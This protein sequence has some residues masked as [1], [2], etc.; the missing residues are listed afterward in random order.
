MPH[1]YFS[2]S[3]QIAARFERRRR[4][5]VVVAVLYALGGLVYL[6]W[7]LTIFNDAS[8]WVSTLYYLAECLGYLLGLTVI[9]GAWRYQHR[10]PQSVSHGYDVDVLIP[11]YKEP[12]GV[13]RKT[14]HAAR[15]IRYPHQ[16]WVLDDAGRLEI[17]A[18]ARELGVHYRARGENWD[19][20]A[21]NLN[22]G[23]RESQ[24]EFVA[25]FDAD[26]IAQPDALDLLLG[27]M[28][29]PCVAMVQT[30]QD[31]YNTDAFQYLNPRRRDGL[32]HDQSY[33]YNLAQPCRDRW[34]AASC[35]GTGVLYRRTALNTIGGIPVDTVTEDFHT[36]LKLHKAGWSTRYL[37][38]PV[39]FGIAAADL[40]EYYKTRHR[41]A[42]GNLATLKHERILTCEGLNWKQRLSYLSLGLIYLEGWQQLLLFLTP[43]FA[44]GF[45]WAAFDI[46]L[47]NV[48]V[49]LAYPVL[50]Y[51]LLQEFGCGFSRFWTNEIFAMARWPVHIAASAALLGKKL[52]W[53][54]SSKN[55]QGVVRWS[56]ML[57]QLAVL[58]VSGTALG[59]G[60]SRLHEDFQVGPLGM[61]LWQWFR[62][63]SLPTD[64]LHAALP[65]GY[66][67]ELVAIAGF[68]ALFNMA[69]ALGFIYK[70]RRN[71]RQ[72]HSSFRFA[73]P[74]PVSL[75]SAGAPSE[76]H[77]TCWIAEDAM[78]LNMANTNLNKH[79]RLQLTLHLPSGDLACTARV[80]HTQSGKVSACFEWA[81]A[82]QHQRLVETLYSIHWQRELQPHHAYFLTPSDV[83]ARLF[84]VQPMAKPK[85]AWY[86]G[87]LYDDNTPS[88]GIPVFVRQSMGAALET[89]LVVFTVLMH[90]QDYRIELPGQTMR[91]QIK[92]NL[93]L[94]SLPH[95]GLHGHICHRYRAILTANISGFG[96]DSSRIRS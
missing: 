81:S 10:T 3:Q 5:R 88:D 46:S 80:T 8:L 16:T 44:L 78:T 52:R 71:A 50:S 91:T 19:A 94:C 92:D 93:P 62:T 9:L 28:D 11:T 95:I 69:R 26:H 72:S 1:T 49:V 55:L 66:S 39:A 65:P 82:T 33:F 79:S 4:L 86:G 25:V 36:S 43:L 70:A 38:E 76:L 77:Q 59:Y 40:E 48:L 60:I 29:D 61:A 90:G 74:L 68:W 2:V 57:P 30:P 56:L 47:F 23:L 75:S 84:G 87:M 18:L 24:A 31:F 12:L 64:V 45:G 15:A 42:H 32:W 58:I 14:V 34:N 20:K 51:I 53:Q 89:E 13:I 85:R 27:L 96:V 21:G 41:W 22:F 63:G 35:V 73:L 83:L 67:V 7:R 54:S 17:E 6:G 37:N